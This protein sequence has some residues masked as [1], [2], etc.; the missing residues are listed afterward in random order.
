MLSS[1]IKASS[2]IS[3][4]DRAF[5]QASKNAFA[6]KNAASPMSKPIAT[7]A[8]DEEDKAIFNAMDVN[9]DGLL[10]ITEYRN[11]MFAN[12]LTEEENEQF[13]DILTE[14]FLWEQMKHMD[15][16]KD[17]Q[18]S[19][20]EMEAAAEAEESESSSEC[21]EDEYETSS[22]DSGEEYET[23]SEASGEEYESED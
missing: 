14:E 23:S 18:F 15:T 1:L 16:D 5:L 13:G 19:L 12:E 21:S 9:E 10:S 2:V 22:E 17:G 20:A 8:F 6:A 3:A 4:G 7:S 11:Y